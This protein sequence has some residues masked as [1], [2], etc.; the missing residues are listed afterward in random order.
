MHWLLQHESQILAVERRL[1]ELRYFRKRR[2]SDNLKMY[3]SYRGTEKL[4]SNAANTALK[5][6]L[7]CKQLSSGACH[8]DRN[9]AFCLLMLI[10]IP[11]FV[12]CW[13]R[14]P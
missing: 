2:H 6:P 12:C 13:F 4:A 9:S 14:S 1:F 8:G 3:T 11:L 5:C 10:E 7:I